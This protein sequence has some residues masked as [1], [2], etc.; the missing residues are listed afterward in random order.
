MKEGQLPVQ[1]SVLE[2]ALEQSTSQQEPPETKGAK[3]R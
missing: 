2:G 3:K 1:E